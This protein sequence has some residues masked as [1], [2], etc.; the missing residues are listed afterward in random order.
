MKKKTLRICFF[1]LI[2]LVAAAV[3]FI[4]NDKSTTSNP[5]ENTSRKTTPSTSSTS[6][7]AGE[8]PGGGVP[9]AAEKPATDTKRS[10]R[11]ERV[12]KWDGDVS[13]P[14]APLRSDAAMG[15]REAFAVAT[16]G[17]TKIDLRPDQDGFFQR[18]HTGYN[19]G[20]DFT[21]RYPGLKSDTD[22]YIGVLDGGKSDV[23][24]PLK[25]DE[26]GAIRFNFVTGPYDG[27]YRIALTTSEN[28]VK[29]M[30]IWVGKPE[31]EQPNTGG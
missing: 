29:M 12:T 13:V 8:S 21:V 16:V 2:F 31:W 24:E 7:L 5:T 11:P 17:E 30:D 26:N 10:Q 19:Q 4:G 20:I 1:A 23:T 6:D 14:T 9:T 25:P 22:V 3:I 27:A 15:G 18:M 28:D